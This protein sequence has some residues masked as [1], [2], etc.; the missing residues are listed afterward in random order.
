M[1]K[2]GSRKSEFISERVKTLHKKRWEIR[3]YFFVF[4]SFL[5]V[6]VFWIIP[7][8]DVLKISFS[9]P[10]QSEWVGLENYIKVMRNEAFKIASKNTAV[11]LVT[12]IPILVILSV[13]ISFWIENFFVKKVFL[14]SFFLI[15]MAMPIALTVLF[16]N[17]TFDIN[18]FFNAILNYC[19]FETKDWLNSKY[20]F[21]ILVFLYI[22]KNI[23]YCIVLCCAALEGLDNGMYESA[24]LDGANKL[25]QF[26]FISIPNLITSF[27]IIIVI[28]TINAFKVFRESYL[29]A[30]DYPQQ[31][32]YMLQNAFNNW[33]RELAVDKMSSAA[34]IS[35]SVLILFV[36]ILEKFWRRKENDI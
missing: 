5:G 22:W 21:Y 9:S 11:F 15:P 12:C 30:G 24:K 29:I 23:G 33:F 7:F 27:F 34:V 10:T 1:C 19:H 8:L 13:L 6:L 16:L 18:G 4:P 3:G 26:L 14:K 25:Q 28:S 35:A 32:I 20:A 17:I 31:S 2:Y 36:F